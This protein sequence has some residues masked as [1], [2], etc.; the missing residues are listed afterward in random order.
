M[1]PLT[2]RT[3]AK[4]LTIKLGNNANSLT[5]ITA[6]VNKVNTVG[7][8]YDSPDTTAYGDAI[9]N[10][11]I[12]QPEAPLS[13]GGPWDTTLHAM[14]ILLNGNPVPR[15]LDIQVGIRAAWEAGAPQ[16]GISQ[17]ATS[18]Y[19]VTDYKPDLDSMTWTA[20]LAV[21]GATAPAW[22]VAAEA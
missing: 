11:V 20:T 8:Q 3:H 4:H 21:F 14:M 2:G 13:I 18:G 12:G 15:S 6:Y 10:V 16:F 5:D 9:K 1:T 17:S 22:G 7:L 19:V